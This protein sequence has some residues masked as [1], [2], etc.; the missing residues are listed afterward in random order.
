MPCHLSSHLHVISGKVLWSHSMS[1]AA[2]HTLD[3]YSVASLLTTQPKLFSPGLYETM[4]STTFKILD[5]ETAL[6]T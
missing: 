6:D 1:S 2:S 5:I 3:Y 4:S